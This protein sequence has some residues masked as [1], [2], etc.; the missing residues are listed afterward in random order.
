MR[1]RSRE[2]ARSLPERAETDSRTG[3]YYM[4]TRSRARFT[5]S[6][7]RLHG[8][9]PPP[10]EN[11]G[12]HEDARRHRHRHQHHQAARR[13]RGGGRLARGA[14]CARRRWCGWAARRCATGRLSPEAIEAG[15][16][17]VEHF[18]KLAGGVRA[19]RSS[20]RSRRAPC[21]RRPT[22]DEFVAAVA[23]AHGRPDRRRSPARRRPGSSTSALRSEFPARHDPLFLSTSA[24]ARRSSSSPT[25]RACSSPR[26]CRSASSGSRDRYARNDPP[27]DRDRQAMKKAI[28]GA[29][30]KAVEAVRKK[31]FKTCVGSSGTI[32]SLSLV[33]EA[34]IL[35][36]EPSPTG[37]RTLTRDG[38]KKVNRL[39]RR[40]TEKDKLRDPGPRSAAPRHRRARRGAARPGSSSAPAPTRS[41]WGSG[42]C[43]RACC[44][45]HVARHGE[46]RSPA[47]ATCARAAWTGCCAAGNAEVLHAA[48]VARLALEIFD[49]THALHQ[50]TATEREWLQYGALLHDIGCYIGYAK[51]QRHSYYLITHGDLTGFSSDEIEVIASLARYH[52]GGRPKEHARELAAARP[53]PAGGRREARRRSC[54]SPTASTAATASSSR[55]CRAAPS[56]RKRRARGERARRLRAR[57]RRGAQEGEPVRARVRPDGRLPGGAGRA[58]RRTCFRRTSR[59]CRPRRCG[60]RETGNGAGG[61]RVKEHFREQLEDLRRQLILMGG[62][63]ERQIHRAIEALTEMDAEKAAPSSP[64][65]RRSTGWRCRSR[66][67]RSRSS[68]CSSPSPSTCGSSSPP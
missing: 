4:K 15:V 45:T 40:T 1:A 2:S 50:L 16:S 9:P 26:A 12:R 24:A 48:H 64:P 53:V 11:R 46:A 60:A 28:R 42:A 10:R 51:H 22:P 25:A 59:S 43:A 54:G 57:A 49:Q 47:T 27:S 30:R 55:A 52:K 38:L 7:H 68:P 58:R 39:L 44:S 3:R 41:S 34:A 19:R 67:R 37:H 17:T 56:A 20:G 29:P 63:V 31:G 8:V 14:L 65:T 35:G 21:A 32:Q 23:E 62:E 61:T 6:S 18:V 33:H 36:R 66:S 5:R 13:Q